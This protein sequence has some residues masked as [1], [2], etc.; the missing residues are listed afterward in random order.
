MPVQIPEPVKLPVKTREVCER[1]GITYYQ[2]MAVFRARKMQR[3]P[4]DSSGDYVWS[5]SDIETLRAALALDRR[6]GPRPRKGA[7]G[8]Q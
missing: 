3:P 1:L 4:Q 8:A 6:L 5:E 2:V 7:N